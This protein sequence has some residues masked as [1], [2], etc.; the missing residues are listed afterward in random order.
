MLKNGRVLLIFFVFFLQV[1]K[2]S[3]RDLYLVLIGLQQLPTPS[4]RSARPSSSNSNEG[5]FELA[6]YRLL[7]ARLWFI[8]QLI[9]AFLSPARFDA[10]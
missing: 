10:V 7:F 1:R 4:F 2:V 3:C 6:I 8:I 5:T 9:F